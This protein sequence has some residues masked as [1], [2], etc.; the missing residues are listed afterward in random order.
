MQQQEET[1]SKNW[2]KAKNPLGPWAATCDIDQKV[3]EGPILMVMCQMV[4][5]QVRCATV[6]LSRP[7]R[8]ISLAMTV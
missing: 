4:L 8:T 5:P 3:R 2:K 1:R 7:T 6:G